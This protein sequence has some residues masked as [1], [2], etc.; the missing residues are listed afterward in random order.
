[1]GRKREVNGNNKGIYGSGCWI[2]MGFMVYLSVLR[3][4]SEIIVMIGEIRPLGR[5]SVWEILVFKKGLDWPDG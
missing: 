5:L 4:G 3:Y 2:R 1:M